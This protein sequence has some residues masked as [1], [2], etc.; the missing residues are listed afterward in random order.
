MF[1]GVGFAT[2]LLAGGLLSGG[3]IASATPTDS[4]VLASL[5][6]NGARSAITQMAETGSELAT[7]SEQY[8]SQKDTESLAKAQQAWKKA[9][10]A[11]SAASPF[12][13]GPVKELQLYKRIGL[14]RSNDTIFEGAT[15]SADFKSMLKLPELRGYAGAEYILFAAK[16]PSAEIS[17]SHLTDVTTEI[18]TLTNKAKNGWD[19]YEEGFTNAG[20]GMPF[21]MA[22]EAMSPVMAAI[23]NTTEFMIR[24]Q[25]GL[26]SNFFKDKAKLENLEAWHSGMTGAGIQATVDSLSIALDGDAPNSLLGLLATKDGLVKKKDPKLAKAIRKDLEKIN[27]SLGKLN[28]KGVPIYTQLEESSSTMKKLYKQLQNFE[29]DLIAASLGLELDVRAGLEAQ[30][31][32][33]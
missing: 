32:R 12:R 22:E 6:R 27:Q 29:E 33:Q 2:F 25:V 23:L 7:T 8:C 5:G 15:S 24:D 17:C 11:W 30:L 3:S 14:W 10:I 21:M 31:S 1:V 19:E 4:D 9:Y 20:D 18:A 13:I 16:D 28:D 26:P